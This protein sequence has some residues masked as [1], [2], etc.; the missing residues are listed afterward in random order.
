MFSISSIIFLIL[1]SNSPRYFVPATALAISRDIICLFCKFLG[2]S[3]FSIKTANCSIIAVFP[4]PGAPKSN[5]LFFVLRQSIS[6]ILF[7]S[8][9]RPITGS[10]SLALANLFKFTPSCS[11]NNFFSFLLFFSYILL[12]N[13]SYMLSKS[14]FILI[15]ILIAIPSPTS[16][17]PANKCSTVTI[18]LLLS[19]LS[20][21]AFSITFFNRGV[22][23]KNS[24]FL[25][26]FPIMLIISF[27]N[28]LYV[29]LYF[30]NLFVKSFLVCNIA[31]TRCSVPTYGCF[32]S[33][34][35]NF[36]LIIISCAS[37]LKLLIILSPF[38]SIL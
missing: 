10:I 37:S 36:A 7:I 24:L 31:N 2:T 4:T 34:I 35:S 25:L 12:V 30:S 13:S 28:L 33:N 16:N 15:N 29:R 9:S 1:S 5:G 22:Y 27:L 17:N 32:N 11:I 19:L 3:P 20:I 23:R 26:P 8:S 14:R 18:P 6:S 38:K 21:I